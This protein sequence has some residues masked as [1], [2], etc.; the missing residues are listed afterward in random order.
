MTGRLL[1][2]TVLVGAAVALAGCSGAAGPPRAAPSG[3]GDGATVP[4][5]VGGV[6]LLVELADTEAERIA[7]L[8]G[9]VVPPGSG[10]VFRFDPPRPVRFTMSGVTEPLVAAF[11][12]DGV[13]LAVSQLA[14]CAGSLARCPTYGPEQPVDSVVEAAPASLPHVATGDRVR[15]G[16]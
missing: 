6:V 1:L 2:A 4:A 10:M 7:G 12:R 5:T 3:H 13:V 16:A 9:R 11:V 15:V 14:P 8:R